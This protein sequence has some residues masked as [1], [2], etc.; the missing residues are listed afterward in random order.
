MKY[1]PHKYSEVFRAEKRDGILLCT[2]P[3]EDINCQVHKPM[4]SRLDLLEA[5]ETIVYVE[6]KILP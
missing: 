6:F 4:S 1:Y 3:S 2:Y 5:K